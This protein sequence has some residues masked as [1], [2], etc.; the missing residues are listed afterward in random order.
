MK[1]K[2][3][4]LKPGKHN[5]EFE[6]SVSDVGLVDPFINGYLLK[7]KID[8]SIHQLIADADLQVKAKLNCDRCGSEFEEE[9]NTQFEVVYL[10]DS[11]EQEE[12]DEIRFISPEEPFI[13]ISQDLHDYSQLALPV[14]VLCKED[15]KGL[16]PHC[17]TDLNNTSCECKDETIDDRWLPLLNLKKKLEE[18]NLN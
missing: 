3:S 8:K 7:V 11:G 15:C 18:D 6:G 13:D 10:V 14:K 2:I 4:N 5:L 1:I 12:S 9:I 16:C 17:G